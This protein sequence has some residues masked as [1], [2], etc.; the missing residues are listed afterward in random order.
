M[1]HGSRGWVLR[2]DREDE[3]KSTTFSEPVGSYRRIGIF[4]SILERHFQVEEKPGF[5]H[6]LIRSITGWHIRVTLVHSQEFCVF[7]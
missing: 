6:I 2:R 1:I 5:R 4:A 3:A 7:K